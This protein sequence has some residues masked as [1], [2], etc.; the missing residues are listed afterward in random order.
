MKLAKVPKAV[1][2]FPSK[3]QLVSNFPQ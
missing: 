2:S 3:A 1:L